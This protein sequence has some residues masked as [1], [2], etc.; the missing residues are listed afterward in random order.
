[1]LKDWK[2]ARRELRAALKLITELRSPNH[3]LRLDFLANL[4]VVTNA[5]GEREEALALA[6]ESVTRT[7]EYLDLTTAALSERQHLAAVASL[8]AR[9]S[10]FLSLAEGKA[11]DAYAEVLYWKRAVM[12]RQRLRHSLD[13]LGTGKARELREELQGLSRRLARLVIAPAT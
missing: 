6:R 7:R 3:P 1:R 13:A 8:R 5:L 11:E 2:E 12:N 9:M 10:L 4:A